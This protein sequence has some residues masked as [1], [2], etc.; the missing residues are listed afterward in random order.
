MALLLQMADAMFPEGQGAPRAM[1]KVDAAAEKSNELLVNAKEAV[2]E[3]WRQRGLDPKKP[4]LTKARLGYALDKEEAVGYVVT[5]AM[6]LP[7][8]SPDEAR[9]IGK[10]IVAL[11]GASGTIGSK[12]KAFKKRGKAAAPQI[13]ALLQTPALLNLEPLPRKSTAPSL[14]PPAPPPPPMPPPPSAGTR[15]SSAE[16]YEK[17]FGSMEAA[18]AAA[19]AER[20]EASMHFL[21]QILQAEKEGDDASELWCDYDEDGVEIRRIQYRRMLKRLS[22]AF[23]ELELQI[24]QLLEGVRADEHNS[25]ACQC[26]TGRLPQWPWVT[27]LPGKGFCECSEASYYIGCAR[28]DWIPPDLPY[29]SGPGGQ[30]S[31]DWA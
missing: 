22:E 2:N 23:P 20:Y 7:R 26:G 14:P 15:A 8:L 28:S 17:V 1:A 31:I 29:I 13:A 19:T 3:L 16:L 12:L 18:K 5:G 25:R 27:A 4:E 30:S 10:R 11:V 21:A 24:P 6:H 9:A